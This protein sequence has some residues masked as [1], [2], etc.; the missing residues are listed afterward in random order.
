MN[1]REA[2]KRKAVAKPLANGH[3][4]AQV[5]SYDPDTNKVTVSNAHTGVAMVSLNPYES[6]NSWIRCAPE[7][8]TEVAIDARGDAKWNEIIAYNSRTGGEKLRAFRSGRGMYRPLQPGEIEVMSSGVAT[9]RFDRRGTT[10]IRGGAVHLELDNE[11]LE[12]KSTAPLHTRNLHLV[13]TGDGERM[14]VVERDGELSREGEHF[15]KE[16]TVSLQFTG[17]PGTL[18]QHQVGHVTDAQGEPMTGRDGRTLRAHFAFH[19]TDGAAD[20]EIADDGSVNVEIPSSARS[21]VTTTI[22]GGNYTLDVSAGAIEVGAARN[23]EITAG[24]AGTLKAR[25]AMTVDGSAVRLGQNASQPAVLGTVLAGSV[26]PAICSAL[27]TIAGGLS[28][29]GQFGPAGAVTAASAAITGMLP[30]LLSK[31]VIVE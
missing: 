9:A 11:R 14:G 10:H 13:G 27:T 25:A 30:A 29:A 5:T 2:K 18:Y 15:R 23:V 24:A 17:E 26:L 7:A 8:G 20:V 16:W 28:G 21:G 12:I 4:G 1:R 3:V 22:G 31:K 6:G 19:G